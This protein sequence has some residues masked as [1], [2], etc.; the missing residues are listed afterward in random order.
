[1]EI[2]FNQPNINN[3]NIFF[4][5]PIK[6][7]NEKFSSFYKL[8]YSNN[9]YSLKYLLINLDIINYTIIQEGY[10]HKLIGNMSET[11]MK[12]IEKIEYTI[13]NSLK[14]NL[15]T[16]KKI[17]IN[18]LNDLKSRG[19]IYIFNEPPDFDKIYLKISGVWEDNT[20]IGLVYKVCYNTSI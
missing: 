20:N 14:N 13:L 12:C 19:Y 11:F 17:S 2:I 15:K 16:K 3:Y 8:L 7:Q 5:K 1:M 10:K 6:N 18:L 9:I 4:K